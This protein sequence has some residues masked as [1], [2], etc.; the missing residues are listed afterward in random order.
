MSQSRK[1]RLLLLAGS[2]YVFVAGSLLLLITLTLAIILLGYSAGESDASGE[3]VARKRPA[4]ITF[5]DQPAPSSSP[6]EVAPV[7]QAAPA[8]G[9]MATATASPAQNNIAA[10][11]SPTLAAD[12]VSNS[13]NVALASAQP[14]TVTSAAPVLVDNSTTNSPIPTPTSGLNTLVVSTPTLTPTPT[15]SVTP[16]PNGPG[17]ITGRVLL[18]G[19][20][21]GGV[22]IKLE[23]QAQKTIAETA[24]GGDG[25]YSFSNLA[26]SGSGYNVVFAQEWN[27]H[28]NLEQ[29]VS[30]AWLGPVAV[31]NGASAQLPDV[32][33]S[34]LGFEPGKPAANATFSAA[35]I[36]PSNPIKFEWSAYPQ[37]TKYWVDLAHGQNQNVIWQAVAQGTSLDFN[38]KLSNGAQIQPGDYWWGVGARRDLGGYKLT[39]YGYLP[40]FVVLP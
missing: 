12:N 35:S 34:L 3:R 37:A 18:N 7:E 26:A 33:V 23:D 22:K 31:Q 29:V 8:A 17:A 14:Q 30:W 4:L 5:D 15:V 19:A 28:F 36:S 2:A 32:D 27:P 38:G 20:P 1:K 10:V 40:V 16:A 6:V 25:R 24:S 39:V 11:E 13:A 21:A 9:Q